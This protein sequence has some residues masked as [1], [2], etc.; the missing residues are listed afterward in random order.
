MAYQNY[1][2]LSSDTEWFGMQEQMISEERPF[3]S[4]SI[5]SFICKHLYFNLLK[6]FNAVL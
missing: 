5:G 4:I 3:I 6:A 1:R 2:L